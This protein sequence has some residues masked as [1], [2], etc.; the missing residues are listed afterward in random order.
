VI[1]IHKLVKGNLDLS[2]GLFI[3]LSAGFD[4]AKRCA[5]GA[6]GQLATRSAGKKGNK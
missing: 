4:S 1:P 3:L 5:G 6:A 2:M